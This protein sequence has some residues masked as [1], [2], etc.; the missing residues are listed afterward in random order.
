MFLYPVLLEKFDT[1]KKRQGNIEQM[2]SANFQFEVSHAGV[3]KNVTIST[4]ATVGNLKA[5]LQ[6][7]F[8]VSVGQQKLIGLMHPDA[9][10]LNSLKLKGP[11]KIM[12][13]GP[14]MGNL[15]SLGKVNAVNEVQ[16]PP[17]ITPNSLR[18]YIASSSVVNMRNYFE[19]LSDNP[20]VLLAIAKAIVGTDLERSV[21]SKLEI[22]S[23]G[24]LE[25]VKHL[26]NLKAAQNSAAL[27][28]VLN[29]Q[30]VNFINML[31][32]SAKD[33]D[34]LN[35]LRT[36]EGIL[37]NDG[38]LTTSE[39]TY[40][41]VVGPTVQNVTR[42][43]SEISTPIFSAIDNMVEPA[44]IK[45]IVE[46]P[47]FD[48]NAQYVLQGSAKQSLFFYT[49]DSGNGKILR[50]LLKAGM[51][52][53]GAEFDAELAKYGGMEKLNAELDS[54][55]EELDDMEDEGGLKTL[56]NEK[57]GAAGG[58][59]KT[60]RSRRKTGRKTKSRRLSRRS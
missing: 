7:L 27:S 6:D 21:L 12:L 11:K 23:K 26:R 42:I 43:V 37:L 35:Y 60:R 32:A 13:V 58:R 50:T 46:Y 49:V 38:I 28:D 39:G 56:F 2:A 51:P 29:Q 33:A 41:K 45:A 1:F 47:G 16:A 15:A 19:S 57:R 8:G 48:W 3:K 34:L 30:T 31:N 55:E 14:K 5:K 25:L 18:A 9:A 17:T 54:M 59:R 44:V 20:E 22:S 53:R 24:Y 10:R 4:N 36:T 52:V 40:R